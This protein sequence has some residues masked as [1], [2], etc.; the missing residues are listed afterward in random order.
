MLN[1]FK[2]KR[3]EQ[4]N[5]DR[6]YRSN[7]LYIG[8]TKKKI[9]KR[10]TP[11]SELSH[12]KPNI[13]SSEK[14]EISIKKITSLKPNEIVSDIKSNTVEGYLRLTQKIRYWLMKT[15]ASVLKYVTNPSTQRVL[16]AIF[17]VAS[18]SLFFFYSSFSTHFI[19]KNY[20]VKFTE[21]SYVDKLTL[22]NMLR[23][24]SQESIAGFAPVN[25]FWFINDESLTSISKQK[26]PTIVQVKVTERIWPNTVELQIETKP[27]L[28]TLNINDQFF[29]ISQN[30]SV[31]GLDEG[32]LK[33]KVVEVVAFQ[34]NFSV[35]ELNRIFTE[36]RNLNSGDFQNS[37]LNRLFFIDKIKPEL[38][39]RK[40]DVVKIE[41]LTLYD[42]DNDVYLYTRNG[43]KLIFD[44]QNMGI[45]NNLKRL[46][47]LT[48][49]TQLGQDLQDGKVAY[50]DLRIKG[51]VYI[52]YQGAEC[53]K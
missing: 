42:K 37:Q 48:E 20:R 15:W 12:K 33:Q 29:L 46:D 1:F 44:S 32:G 6:P 38:K 11:L 27:I 2:T 34:K 14:P 17:L 40:L 19:V 24:F 7:K 8:V 5:E 23:R 16:V 4:P 28:A 22:S 3:E 45:E 36:N 50:L 35:E 52:C 9:E 41:L 10:R 53:D 39:D 21:G 25:H 13:N 18:L 31:I 49:T 43:T 51:I 26:N 47:I 30:G